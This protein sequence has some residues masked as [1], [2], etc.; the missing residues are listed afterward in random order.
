MRHTVTVS[1]CARCLSQY[2]ADLL[3]EKHFRLKVLAKA[4]CCAADGARPGCAP[5]W[6]TTL[7]H[8]FNW[9]WQ[10][11]GLADAVRALQTKL[12]QLEGDDLAAASDQEALATSLATVLSRCFTRRQS[13]HASH[14][15]VTPL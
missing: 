11:D 2:T 7:R 13:N 15:V 14:C 4:V 3:K 10:A 9:A 6:M 1:C 12:G 5:F 8:R